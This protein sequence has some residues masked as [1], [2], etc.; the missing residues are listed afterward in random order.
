[1]IETIIIA[2]IVSKLKGYDI[3]PL[4]KSWAFYPVIIMELLYW[5]GQVLIWSGH[6]EVINILTLSKSIYMCSYLFLILK[7]EL[8]ISAFWGAFFTIIG[9]ILNDI[10]IKVNDGFMP[11]FPT[12]SILIGHVAPGGINIA[13][14]IHILGSTDTQLKI[15][16]DFIDLGYSVL[17]IG[18]VLIRVFMFLVVYNSIKKINLTIEEK[19]KC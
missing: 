6:Y 15:L 1:M 18:D 2:F 16:T 12:I 7:Y 3:K 4:F 10:A 8:Y 17:S 14:D 9:G 5:T 11:V 19:I 13:N